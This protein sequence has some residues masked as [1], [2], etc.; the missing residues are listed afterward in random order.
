MSS[1][2]GEAKGINLNRASPEELN[3]VGGLGDERVQRLI[4]NRPYRSWDDLKK[5]EGFGGTL[6][7]DLKNA[8]AQ[9]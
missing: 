5:V 8:G 2:I 4:K 1:A 3:R 6:V 9:I 7:E